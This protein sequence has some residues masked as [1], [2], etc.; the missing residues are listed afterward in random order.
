[1]EGMYEF[2]ALNIIRRIIMVTM[3]DCIQSISM[4]G[5]IDR[6]A[7]YS[8][9]EAAKI[10]G[11]SP[12][13]LRYYDSLNLIPFIKRDKKNKRLF[14]D[15]DIQWL[16]LVECLRRTEMSLPDIQ[17]YLQL[18][19]AGEETLEERLDIIEKQEGI[20]KK[21]IEDMNYALKL[22]RFKRDYYTSISNDP[23]LKKRLNEIII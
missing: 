8:V 14:S 13:T 17:Y 23:K 20:M 6:T 5:E 22:L 9:N 15:V 11:I 2:R 19:L 18:S 1:M 10:T 12:H 21:H 16:K 3:E 7:K 4:D